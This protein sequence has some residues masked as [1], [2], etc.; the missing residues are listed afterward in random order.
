[1]ALTFSDVRVEEDNEWQWYVTVQPVT[2]GRP[3]SNW[4]ITEDA[5]VIRLWQD[6]VK[7]IELVKDGNVPKSKNIKSIYTYS[8]D[9]QI[10][11]LDGKNGIQLTI[12]PTEDDSLI[13]D[14]RTARN[15]SHPQ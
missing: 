1:M 13:A 15:F 10:I 3:D 2:R 8:Y 7:E 9:K 5:E 12:P 11:L 6:R 4:W 14:W